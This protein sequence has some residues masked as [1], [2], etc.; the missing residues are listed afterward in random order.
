M[1]TNLA[2]YN[3]VSFTTTRWK[4]NI[5]HIICLFISSQEFQFVNNLYTIWTW[6]TGTEGRGVQLDG[7][8]KVT[9]KVTVSR[10]QVSEFVTST[11]KLSGLLM[12]SAV[13]QVTQASDWLFTG[14]TPENLT[15]MDRHCCY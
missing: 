3:G 1:F 11:E 7:R 5:L 14:I 15:Q 8:L 12:K 13:P 10:S 4:T 6:V 9:P 2:D